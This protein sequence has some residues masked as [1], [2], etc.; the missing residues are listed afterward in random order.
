MYR[1]V[2]CVLTLLIATRT[3]GAQSANDAPTSKCWRFAFGAWTP[4]LNWENAG[5]EGRASDLANRVQRVRD[6]VFAKDTNAVRNNAMYWE[7][8]KGRWSVVLFPEWWPVGVK[9]EFDS[10]LAHGREMTG[11][12]IA[13]VGDAGKPPARARARAVRCP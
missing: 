4:P 11:E 5:H 12:A 8:V 2:C 13:L 7:Q 3:A 10:V 1:I 9:V 6:S